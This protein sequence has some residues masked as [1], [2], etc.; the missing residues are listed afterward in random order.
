MS[1]IHTVFLAAQVLWL[2]MVADPGV[3]ML[4]RVSCAVF[5][6]VAA[7]VAIRAAVATNSLELTWSAR[8]CRIYRV[9]M[10]MLAVSLV[11]IALYFTAAGVFEVARTSSPVRLIAAD[12]IFTVH[13]WIEILI[14]VFLRAQYG[15]KRA[16]LGMAPA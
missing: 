12:I 13:L 9:L 8:E 1:D 11:C 5:A 10:S 14:L 2:S 4:L 3:L 15:K 16:R 7:T 6:I